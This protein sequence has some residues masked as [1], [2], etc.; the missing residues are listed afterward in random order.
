MTKVLKLENLTGISKLYIFREPGQSGDTFVPNMLRKLQEIGWKGDTRIVSLASHKDPSEL[1]CADPAEFKDKFQAA[2]EAAHEAPKCS[3]LEASSE[4]PG[5]EHDDLYFVEGGRI[6]YRKKTA[7][8]SV[9][10]PL[11]NF[12]AS[13]ADEITRDDGSETRRMFRIEGK[14][15]NGE[16][17]APVRVSSA[18]FSSMR[19]TTANWGIRARV[20]AGFGAQDKLREAIQ[21]FSAGAKQ[22]RVFTHTGWAQLGDQAVFLTANG[23]IGRADVEVELPAELRAY[24]LPQKPENVREAMELSLRLLDV[25][26]LTITAPFLAAIFRAPLAS[27]FPVDVSLLA[28]GKTGTQKS[29]LAA[30]FLCHFGNFERVSLPGSFLSTASRTFAVEG[31]G[32]G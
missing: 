18:E 17:L 7:D 10:I 2:L 21:A 15:C 24:C 19:W 27:A 25:A 16:K 4:G 29:T 26:P 1:H 8:G 20:S 3:E 32:N 6:C 11:C 28:Q 14:L 30:L 12:T 9:T 22:R 13:V 5:S 31:L 23:A